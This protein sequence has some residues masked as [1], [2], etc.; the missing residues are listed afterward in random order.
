MPVGGLVVAALIALLGP[1]CA[2]GRCK[3]LEAER[4]ALQS[5]TGAPTQAPHARVQ[6]PF[7]LANQLIA[8]ALRPP[9]E[10]PVPLARLG[11]LAQFIGD[12]RAIPREI[13][14]GPSETA[15][16]V[17]ATA[18]VELADRTGELLT[19]RASGDVAPV[20]EPGDGAD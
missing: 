20:F 17:R 16:R 14:L 1:A 5:R 3:T 13:T 8:D 2:S 4:Q 15:G 7:L 18:R 10:L 9:P 19:V 12:V 11:P 6:I